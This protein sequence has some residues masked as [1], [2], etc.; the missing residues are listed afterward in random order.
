MEY[1][2]AVQKDIP[3]VAKKV[4]HSAVPMEFEM[5]VMRER[6]KVAQ[7]APSL[8]DQMDQQSDEL[9]ADRTVDLSVHQL[10]YRLAD[11]WVDHSAQHS[12]D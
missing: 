2:R 3:S 5:A 6:W 1:M 11:N 7:M 8:V 12:A 9:K 4:T 10:V